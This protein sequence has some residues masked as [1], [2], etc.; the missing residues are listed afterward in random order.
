MEMI[1]MIGADQGCHTLR[2]MDAGWKDLQIC[3]TEKKETLNHFLSF[4][5]ANLMDHPMERRHLFSANARGANREPLSDLP[6][7]INQAQGI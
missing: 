7:R 5:L 2:A 6:I 4:Q 1:V 3:C